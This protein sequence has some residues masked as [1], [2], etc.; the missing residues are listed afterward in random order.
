MLFHKH[1]AAHTQSRAAGF[2]VILLLSVAVMAVALCSLSIGS[3]KIPVGDIMQVFFY[4]EKT[5]THFSTIIWEIR[6]PKICTAILTGA[7][8]AVSGLQM[9]TLFRNPLAGP[10]I[11]GIS[12]GA[13]LGVALL[14]LTAGTSG[15]SLFNGGGTAG[16]W[17]IAG[18]SVAGAAAAM[19]LILFI[20]LRV[21]DVTTLLL[22]GMM[23]AGATGAL[24]SILQYWSEK[25]ALQAFVFWTFGSLRGVTWEQL[26][27]LFPAVF[28]GL[29]GGL[30]LSK[31]L[32][33]LPAGE[34]YAKSLGLHVQRSRFLII[35]CTSLLAGAATA[36]CGPIAFI[37]LAT[38][39]VTR[40]FFDTT[41]HLLL[42][43]ATAL[44]GSLLL[45]G[46]DM[47]SQLPGSE[48]TLPVNAV[49]SLLGAPFVIWL[50]WKGQNL[51]SRF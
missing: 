13:S 42:T 16:S 20:S 4:P 40:L 30:L 45:L 8:L 9:Q 21:R 31:S 15:F 29:A 37:G 48:L 7:A 50:I 10:Y 41:D 11:L 33:V 2:S 23:L 34:N 19:S 44:T 49:T 14:I 24:V 1:R 27:V 5:S 46:C 28:V 6:L 38:P 43:P 22:I 3:V 36:F 47:I 32:N 51:S 39:H 18:A 26:A 25:E 17:A 35:L 12:S